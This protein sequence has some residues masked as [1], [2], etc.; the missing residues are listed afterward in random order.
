MVGSG[1]GIGNIMIYIYFKI[2]EY[3]INIKCDE[4]RRKHIVICYILLKSMIIIKS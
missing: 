4:T 3:T 1:Y 2:D